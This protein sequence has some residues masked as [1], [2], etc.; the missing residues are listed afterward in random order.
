MGWGGL[1]AMRLADDDRTIAIWDR[2]APA[3]KRTIAELNSRDARAMALEVDVASLESLEA[4]HATTVDFLGPVDIL[5]NAAA[6]IGVDASVLE[7]PLDE[8]ERV[9]A[10][11]SDGDVPGVTAGGWRHGGAGLGANRQ[12]HIRRPAW[13]RRPL[14]PIR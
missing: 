4:A 9:L 10:G 1:R 13:G 12:L 6:I 11:Q 3:A 8:W 14:F 7:T 5:V 2:D